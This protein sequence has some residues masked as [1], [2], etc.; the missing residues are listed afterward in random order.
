MP[1][2]NVA[3]TDEN[4]NL[5]EP[6][7]NSGVAVG[8]GYPK[9]YFALYDFSVNGGAQGTISLVAPELPDN[10]IVYDI[11]WDVR[12]T[13]TSST[14][15]ATITV[16]FPTDGNMFAPTAISSPSNIWDAGG[17]APAGARSPVKLTAARVPQITVAGG[18]DLTAGVVMF[19][20]STWQSS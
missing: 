1:I 3:H 5:L 11:N 17:R 6:I 18:Q 16:G 13:L 12:T 20:F 4:G 2:S 9:F 7:P 10:T 19:C 14:D 15:A 8:S